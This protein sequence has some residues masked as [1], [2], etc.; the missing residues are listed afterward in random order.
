MRHIAVACI[1]A[2]AFYAGAAQIASAGGIPIRARV[3]STP[4][5]AFVVP[6]NWTGFYAGVLIGG[7]WGN[8]DFSNTAGFANSY[9]SKGYLVGGLLGLNWQF[10]RWVLGVETDLSYSRIAGDDDGIGGATDQTKLRWLGSA[11]ARVGY[12]FDTWLVYGTA[13]F[14]Y[15]S[16]RH[17]SFAPP[18]LD[19]FSSTETGW[20]VGAGIEYAL[21]DHWSARLD[22]RYYD[23]GSYSRSTPANGVAPY[24][25]D[26]TFHI[27]T[28][29]ANYKFRPF[30]W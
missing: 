13:G 18:L 26:N 24:S 22:Y 4:P 25:V 8:H 14:A 5:P 6:Y 30:G 16:L 15:G 21:S 28:F 2:A 19:T 23:L 12:T 17:S 7:G 11:R 27:L 9:D 3:D 29:V 1:T 10:N 20:T